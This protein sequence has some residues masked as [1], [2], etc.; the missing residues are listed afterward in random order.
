[1]NRTFVLV[2]EP[3][4]PWLAPEA[5]VTLSSSGSSRTPDTSISTF[6]FKA[7]RKVFLS[8]GG[9]PRLDLPVER[10]SVAR[11]DC[12]AAATPGGSPRRGRARAHLAP[13]VGV[14]WPVQATSIGKRKF[15]S[16]DDYAASRVNLAT[17]DDR[18]LMLHSVSPMPRW[19]SQPA[20]ISRRRASPRAIAVVCFRRL[21]CAGVKG[22]RPPSE[23][24]APGQEFG[25]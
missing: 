19:P 20:E 13:P 4:S 12:D 2:L 9:R 17:S 14:E 23:L 22:L 15:G 10:S 8:L 16:I 7:S 5:S 3:S 21:C 24:P 1:M 11:A 25:P 18:R 6:S